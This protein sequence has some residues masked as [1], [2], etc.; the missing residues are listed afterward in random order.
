VAVLIHLSFS[1]LK[2]RVCAHPSSGQFHESRS[3]SPNAHVAVHF[4]SRS[5]SPKIAPTAFESQAMA[6]SPEG[7][8]T[9]GASVVVATS[10]VVVAMTGAGVVS[11][12]VCDDVEQPPTMRVAATIESTRFTL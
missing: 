7:G 4:S 2:M 12:A 8:F 3:V 11:E 10:V 9:S 5:F 1:S 6:A